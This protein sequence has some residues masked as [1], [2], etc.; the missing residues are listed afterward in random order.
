MHGRSNVLERSE[1]A[2]GDSRDFRSK[3]KLEGW[4]GSLNSQTYRNLCVPVIN[5]MDIWLQRDIC[6]D[7]VKRMSRCVPA[8]SR[9]ASRLSWNGTF[10]GCG[11]RCSGSGAGRPTAQA[12][13]WSLECDQPA[14][15]GVASNDDPA[16]VDVPVTGLAALRA[17]PQPGGGLGG[18]AAARW[19]EDPW[20]GQDQIGRDDLGQLLQVQIL[21]DFWFSWSLSQQKRLFCCNQGK[22]FCFETLVG[23]RLRQS[24]DLRSTPCLV[25]GYLS[26]HLLVAFVP[27]T[28]HL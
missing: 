17:G 1:Q 27:N 6:H 5:E 21:F 23:W 28:W 14:A 16:V 26:I 19:H 11:P 10:P 18:T 12:W 7:W 15:A 2:R 22:R 4:Q 9:S 25:V 24:S 13:T 3:V 8:F 20:P